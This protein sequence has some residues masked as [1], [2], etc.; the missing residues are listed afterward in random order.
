MELITLLPEYYK[1]NKTMEELQGIL[2]T[3]INHLAN[4]I[5]TAID[6]CFVN[7][8]TA[9]L[10]RYEKIYGIQVEVSKSNEFRRE[11]IR[12]KIRGTGTVTKQMIENVAKSY[13]N[14]DVEVIENTEDYSFK[15]KFVGT[16]GIPDN[17]ADLTLTI[18]EIKP[19][20]LSFSFE[21]TYNTW[22]DIANM[23]WDEAS[24]YTWEQLRV[25]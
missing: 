4:N 17:M 3:D 21:Y 23:T 18:N 5:N 16:K 15:V 12:A 14:G 1:G 9:L 8:A 10:S 22:N 2:S 25:R 20:H 13:S 19:A 6:Q 24:A 11:R 7:T